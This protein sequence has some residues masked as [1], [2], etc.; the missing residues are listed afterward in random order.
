MIVQ[1][2]IGSAQQV[3]SPKYFIFCHQ[4]KDRTSAPEIKITIAFFDNL[5]LRKYH[6][7]IDSI[8]DP[9]DILLID[10]EQNDYIE[11][12]K[13]LKLFFIEYIGEP[14]LYP[15]ISYPDMKTKYP[16]ETIDLRRQPDHITLKKNQ[17]F[18]EHGT[19]P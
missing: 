7:E 19:D 8:R 18:Q 11:Q 15:I 9:R 4:T 6:I 3:K 14:I 16:I 13:D 5:D 12:Y 1:H 10:Y 17:L 2:V